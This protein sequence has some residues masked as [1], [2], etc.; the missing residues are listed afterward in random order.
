VK[1]ESLLDE[2]RALARK[3]AAAAPRAHRSTLAA[4]DAGLDRTLDQGL[5]GE[6]DLFGGCFR[7]RDMKEGTSAFLEKRPPRFAGE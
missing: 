7:T 2:A 3:M 5:A 1:K 6:A 4:V